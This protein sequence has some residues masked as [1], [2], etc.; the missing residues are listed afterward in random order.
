MICTKTRSAKAIPY[1]A[2]RIQCNYT[3]EK[4]ASVYVM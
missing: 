3:S 4:A 2:L 1:S